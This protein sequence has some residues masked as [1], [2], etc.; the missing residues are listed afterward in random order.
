MRKYKNLFGQFST[1][2]V[3]LLVG[4]APCAAVT[5]LEVWVRTA[6][7]YGSGNVEPP[8]TAP[9][10]LVLDKLPQQQGQRSDAQYGNAA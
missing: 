9:K 2:I 5:N 1:A 3:L 4:A 6:G 7:S 8:K 10:A